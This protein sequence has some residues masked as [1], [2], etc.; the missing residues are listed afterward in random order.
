M[1]TESQTEWMAESLRLTLFLADSNLDASVTSLWSQIANSEPEMQTTQKTGPRVHASGPLEGQ[2]SIFTLDAQPGRI[3]LSLS[4]ML[5]NDTKLDNFPS[6]GTWAK[7]VELYRSLFLP[8]ISRAPAANR[9]A[10]GTLV[11]TGVADRA[12]GYRYLQRFLTSVKLDPDGS[13]DFSYSINRPRPS[14]VDAAIKI[15]RLS[16]WSVAA[17]SNFEIEFAPGIRRTVNQETGLHACRV[18]LDIN[19]AGM[20]RPAIVGE[21]AERV[22]TELTGLAEE[23]LANG[24]VP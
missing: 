18:E 24:D 1:A 6:F 15:N 3:D 9:I 16:K 21:K 12:A 17:L 19:T 20:L 23:I 13:S 22:L 14:T 2:P 11:T 8:W 4:T 5:P 10:F 7:G